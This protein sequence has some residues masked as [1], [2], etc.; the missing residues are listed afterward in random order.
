MKKFIAILFVS[1]FA[2][3]SVAQVK[4]VVPELT[5]AQKYNMA[6]GA[7]NSVNIYLISYAK[8]QGKSIEDV[9]GFSAD[10]YIS[11]MDKKI[12]FDGYVKSMLSGW[13]TTN[14]GGKVEILEQADK[15]IVYKVT[16]FNSQ[17]KEKGQI[18][19]VKYEEYMKYLEFRQNK[20]AGVYDATFSIKI[21]AEGLIITIEKK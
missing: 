1:L 15:K 18:N 21:I 6:V 20:I 16:N 10:L 12:G 2:M 9:A 13:I 8:S 19:N 5:D 4:F 17:L 3:G 7:W 14:P 11:G